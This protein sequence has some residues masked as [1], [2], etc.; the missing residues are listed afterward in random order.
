LF[1]YNANAGSPIYQIH[2]AEC[3]FA[4][5]RDRTAGRFGL[6]YTDHTGFWVDQREYV[7]VLDGSDTMLVLSSRFSGGPG[8]NVQRGFGVESCTLA[9]PSRFDPCIADPESCAQMIDWFGSCVETSDAS[10]LAE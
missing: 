8:E 6:T 4:A 10:C 3:L 7:F 5:L 9:E 2:G 1:E